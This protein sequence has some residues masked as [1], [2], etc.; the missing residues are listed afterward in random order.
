MEDKDIDKVFR[1]AF[2]EAE[3][4]PSPLLW[5]K[6]EE[7]L[8]SVKPIRTTSKKL[9]WWAYAA[10]AL[11]VI[12][13][14]IHLSTRK[15][16]ASHKI[17]LTAKTAPTTLQ[18]PPA[19][20]ATIEKT[21]ESATVAYTPQKNTQL[22][23]KSSTKENHTVDKKQLVVLESLTED[24]KVAHLKLD[25]TTPTRPLL[26]QVT[27]IDDIKPFIEFE[28]EQETMLAHSK[29]KGQEKKNIVT[30]LLN[31]ITDNF[32]S[33]INK[34]VRFHADEEGSF[35]LSILNTIAKNPNK[36]IK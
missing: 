14:G 4:T 29:P 11:L 16:N 2:I 5:S 32:D 19:K 33:K 23:A 9:N 28:E 22:H 25:T 17:K 8:A 27:E 10:A 34:E 24:L 36:K 1:D 18:L 6:I 7:Q 21:A 3:E 26:R 12:G 30:S 35:S 31:N 13:F 20:N 15:F